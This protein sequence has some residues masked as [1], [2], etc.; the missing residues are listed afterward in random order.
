MDECCG[1]AFPLL[2]KD[3]AFDL[4]FFISHCCYSRNFSFFS[5]VRC[6]CF[7]SAAFYIFLFSFSFSPWTFF[8]FYLS[9][10]TMM[11]MTT[12]RRQCTIYSRRYPPILPPFLLTSSYPYI[13]TYSHDHCR[14]F[15]LLIFTIDCSTGSRTYPS[16]VVFF[17]CSLLFAL[18]CT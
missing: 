6:I 16:E 7:P 18:K 11:M 2:G 9:T 14:L 15:I 4:S 17:F 8:F 13:H 5:L 1:V 12:N 3:V 10:Y